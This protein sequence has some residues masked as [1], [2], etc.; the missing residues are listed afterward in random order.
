MILLVLINMFLA[1]M[2]DAFSAV[3]QE[4][5]KN[6][7]LVRTI[8][9][10]SSVIQ[11]LMR[12]WFLA[13]FQDTGLSLGQMFAAAFHKFARFFHGKKQSNAA[14][15]PA[16][17]LTIMFLFLVCRAIS[18]REHKTCRQEPRQYGYT[19]QISSSFSILQCTSLT[20]TQQRELEEAIVAIPGMEKENVDAAA[21]S[22]LF[23]HL[24]VATFSCLNV[25]FAGC[26][27]QQGLM[28]EFD[29]DND[30][31]LDPVRSQ[32]ERSCQFVKLLCFLTDRKNSSEW[33]QQWLNL[34]G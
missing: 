13:L 11:L 5:A 7:D 32:M 28:K 20:L 8:I 9:M 23:D 15:L 19:G 12:V 3:R 4:D 22:F 16:F 34:L 2:N 29:T 14:R 21:V 26:Y 25:S 30:G 18:C 31:I 24:F 10:N 6:P 27:L 1:I 33:K 17:H